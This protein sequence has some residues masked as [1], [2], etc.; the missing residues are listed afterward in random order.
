MK[1]KRRTPLAEGFSEGVQIIQKLRTPE[2]LLHQGQ[3][4]ADV[5]RTLE[6]S[7][8]TCHR[9]QQLC[10]GMEATEAKRL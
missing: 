4:V 3:T 1:R 7:A 2:Q 9:W 10:G 5:C 6:V 8:P